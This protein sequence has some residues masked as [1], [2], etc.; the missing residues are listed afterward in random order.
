MEVP[1]G[2]GGL[3]DAAGNARGCYRPLINTRLEARLPK[4]ISYRRVKHS[5]HANVE[6]KGPLATAIPQVLVSSL[7][8]N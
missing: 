6:T 5:L 1:L 4:L 3:G 2:R 8:R 7:E